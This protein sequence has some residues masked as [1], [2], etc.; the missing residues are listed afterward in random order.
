VRTCSESGVKEIE[1]GDIYIN[2]LM[3]E[4]NYENIEPMAE[5][6]LPQPSELS[7]TSEA[8]LLE[9]IEDLEMLTVDPD[10]AEDYLLAQFDD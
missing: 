8:E 2:F 9:E 7:P 10:E 3:I 1:I 4:Q 5:N 6:Q